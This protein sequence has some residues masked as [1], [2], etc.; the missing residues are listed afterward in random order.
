MKTMHLFDLEKLCAALP[1]FSP[2]ENIFP[3][4]VD[5][6]KVRRT[7]FAKR[8]SSLGECILALNAKIR[9]PKKCV[10]FPQNSHLYQKFTSVPVNKLCVAENISLI[11]R[12]LAHNFIQEINPH[13]WCRGAPR[14]TFVSQP[15]AQEYP[16]H[17]PWKWHLPCRDKGT[18]MSNCKL[19]T[20]VNVLQLLKQK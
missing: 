19:D 18:R 16:S 17:S 4:S 7:C 3:F 6:A 9:S 13:D 8:L 20:L 10:S 1:H 12:K 14:N 5:H 2:P 15:Q 11:T